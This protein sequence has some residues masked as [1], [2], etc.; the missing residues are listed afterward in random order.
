MKRFLFI[1]LVLL[2]YAQDM[3]GNSQSREK[4]L[5]VFAHP[6]DETMLGS[7]LLKWK[8]AGIPI[9][10]L[11]VTGGEGGKK[12]EVKSSGEQVPLQIPA[13][14]LRA[15][16]AKEMAKAAKNYGIQDLLQ[17][18]ESDLALRAQAGVPSRNGTAFLQ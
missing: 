6:D 3:Q 9:S 5:L 2:A 14:E 18:N 17:L 12:L 10:A 11:Y 16:R 1:W 15:L 7:F 8:A 4:I 13:E